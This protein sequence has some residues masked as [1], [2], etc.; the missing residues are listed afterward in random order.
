MEK[1]PEWNDLRVFLSVARLGTISLAGE[2]LGIEHTTVS[3]RIDRLEAS[4]GV[5]LF[6]RR[7][8]GYTLTEAG[9]ALIPHA[10]KMESALFE[11]IDESLGKEG[12][13]Q[14]TV[15]VGT[16]EAFGIHVLAPSLVQLRREHPGLHI[17]LMAQPQ[18]PSLVTREVEILVTLEP[19]EMGRYKIARLAEVDYYLFYSAAYRDSHPP[20][21]QLADIENHEFVDYIHDGSVSNRYRILEELTPKPLRGFTTTSVLAQRAAA[22]AG[23]GLVLLTPYVAQLDERLLSVFPG[24]SL[25]TRSLWIAA[26]EDLLRIKRVRFVWDHI[27]TLIEQH[28]EHFR[29]HN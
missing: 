11:A 18:F 9:N 14:G 21:T 12:Q 1:H 3:R 17:E 28:P 29:L 8:S 4:L 5:V 6:D 19:P 23:M 26:P 10:E 7:R 22:A 24:H 13:I 16:P 15:R 25:M 20:I 2:R 27:R